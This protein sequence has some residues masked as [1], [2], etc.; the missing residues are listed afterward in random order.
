MRAVLLGVCVSA[1]VATGVSRRLK[2]L[3]AKELAQKRGGGQVQALADHGSA[4]SPSRV[5][6]SYTPVSKPIRVREEVERAMAQL[7]DRQRELIV[8]RDLCEMDY[9]EIAVLA[10]L[11]TAHSARRALSEAW[12]ALMN[13]SAN[14]ST[15]ASGDPTTRDDRSGA[16]GQE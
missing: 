2:D 10:N 7:T 6:G 4:L 8:Y 15:E 9:D 16:E 13:I 14:K 1:W 5:A 3:R 12:T 11:K